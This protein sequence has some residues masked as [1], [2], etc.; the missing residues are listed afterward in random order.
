M[1]TKS[2][3]K[4][5]KADS[6]STAVAVLQQT[7]T[8]VPKPTKTELVDAMVQLAFR[9]WHTANE[10]AKIELKRIDDLLHA[11]ALKELESRKAMEHAP[12]FH[13]REYSNTV[14]IEF[15]FKGDS[16]QRLMALRKPVDRVASSRF[17]EKAT[18]DNIRERI[19]DREERV[20][21]ILSVPEN[22]ERLEGL[23]KQLLIG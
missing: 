2:T 16:I 11:A 7:P 5:V 14:E 12:R 10:E 1:K 6:P 3:P 22:V 19:S 15:N 21:L 20:N 9:K 13:I 23:M 18:R 4:T 17:D 8:V